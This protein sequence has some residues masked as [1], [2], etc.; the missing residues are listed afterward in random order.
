VVRTHTELT[1]IEFRVLLAVE[2][3]RGDAGKARDEL[4]KGG[5]SKLP[6]GVP[7]TTLTSL[8]KR[9]LIRSSDDRNYHLV[10]DSGRQTC[11][12]KIKRLRELIEYA[13]KTL[14]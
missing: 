6:F 12:D 11:R 14:R 10:T 13:E 1:E 7:K 2:A 4:K 5:L 8:K 3:A 9:G